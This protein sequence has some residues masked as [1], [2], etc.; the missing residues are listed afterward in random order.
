MV[1]EEKS[2]RNPYEALDEE[3]EENM[4]LEGQLA[5]TDQAQLPGEEYNW[6]RRAMATRAAASTNSHRLSTAPPRVPN[7]NRHRDSGKESGRNKA[8]GKDL[9]PA[10]YKEY[11]TLLGYRPS[12]YLTA[13]ADVVEALQTRLSEEQ[14]SPI[15]ELAARTTILDGVFK[16][17]WIVVRGLRQCTLEHEVFIYDL[18]DVLFSLG[19]KVT[20]EAMLRAKSTGFI[21]CG[22]DRFDLFIELNEV[23]QFGPYGLHDADILPFHQVKKGELLR[24]PQIL[25]C[26]HGVPFHAGLPIENST[27]CEFL[28][29]RGVPRTHNGAMLQQLLVAAYVLLHRAGVDMSKIALY[30]SDD[31]VYQEGRSYGY[32]MVVRALWLDSESRREGVEKARTAFHLPQNG[33]WTMK[34]HIA[35]TIRTSLGWRFVC[36]QTMA[37]AINHRGFVSPLKEPIRATIIRRLPLDAS[38]ETVFRLLALDRSNHPDLRRVQTIV[39]TRDKMFSSL[40]LTWKGAVPLHLDTKMLNEVFN[41]SRPATSEDFKAMQLMVKSFDTT[42]NAGTAPTSRATSPATSR[43]GSPPTSR[44]GSPA[45]GRPPG[46]RRTSSPHPSAERHQSTTSTSTSPPRSVLKTGLTYAGAVQGRTSPPRVTLGPTRA[47]PYS[48][49]QSPAALNPL[50]R[51]REVDQTIIEDNIRK[52]EELSEICMLRAQLRAQNEENSRLGTQLG[53]ALEQIELLTLALRQAGLLPEPPEV[54]MTFDEERKRGARE[55]AQKSNSKA[56]RHEAPRNSDLGSSP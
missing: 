5:A 14:R 52:A 23:Q 39:M 47:C 38:T 19:Y 8:K 4:D 45:R 56:A 40:L 10:V 32:E 1:E 36:Y 48:P 26:I 54:E 16:S 53:K 42:S 44:A 3:V 18:G 7:D 6:A 51:E 9:T 11:E 31:K 17:K 21:S 41:E 34:A 12:N 35:H 29:L 46:P 15:N 24:N 20:E 55:A 22:R 30:L 13:G 27:A 49:R 37:A 28:A 50:R 33:K 25:Y 43:A 2:S